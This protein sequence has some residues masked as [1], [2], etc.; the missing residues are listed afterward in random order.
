MTYVFRIMLSF[1][2]RIYGLMWGVVVVMVKGL[3]LE[4]IEKIM[5]YVK[6]SR[7]TNMF[8][9]LML[10]YGYGYGFLLLNV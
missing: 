9:V 8:I 3:G 5:T 7:D 2:Y 6:F 10:F 4:K 1:I